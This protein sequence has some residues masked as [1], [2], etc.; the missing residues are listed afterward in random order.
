MATA[1]DTETP[2]ASARIPWLSREGKFRFEMG[3]RQGDESFF[4][5]SSR[6]V[7]ILAEREAVLTANPARY[8]AM[9]D[10]GAD[11]LQKLR[12]YARKS[13]G[14]DLAND[15][16]SITDPCI[17]LGRKWE[18]DF[19]LLKPTADGVHRLVG[20]CICF[21][22]SWDLREKLGHPVDVIHEPVPTV[23]ENLGSQIS[24]FLR[25]IKPGVVWERW[26][27]GMA[28]V[29]D[30]NHHPALAHPRLVEGSTLADSWLRVEHQA[31]RSLD[32]DGGLLFGIRIT[33]ISLTEFTRNRDAALRLAELLETMPDDIAVYKSLATAR[34]PLARQ[35]REAA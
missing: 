2:Q 31:F 9:L 8:A 25:R 7:E 10:E 11:L 30:W 19:L 35:L 14:V 6:N 22:S 17:D 20:G 23:N 1:T 33:V 4:Q 16:A 5:A 3:L 28:A 18:P 15:G 32:A 29:D 27:W 12:A 34:L 13:A 26:N 24:A 21:P